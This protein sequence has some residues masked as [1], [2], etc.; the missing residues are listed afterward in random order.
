MSTRALA[1]AP[2]GAVTVSGPSASDARSTATSAQPAARSAADVGGPATST[3]STTSSGQTLAM[4]SAMPG[5]RTTR[6]VP[7]PSTWTPAPIGGRFGPR[8]TMSSLLYSTRTARPWRSA[9][10]LA[11]SADL[12]RHLAPEG[13]AVGQRRHRNTARLAPRCVGLEV[14]GFDPRRLQR[15]VPV[16]WWRVDRPRQRRCGAPS[17]HLGGHPP[18]LAERLA[19]VPLARR[20]REQR[21]VHPRAP[22]RRR[23]RPCRVPHGRRPT[24]RSRPPTA[25]ARSTCPVGCRGNRARSEGQHGVDDG[26]PSGAPAQVGGEGTVHGVDRRA[27]L[28]RRDAH[29]D[30]RRAEPALRRA[31]R[32]ERLGPCHRVGEPIDRRDVPPG[33]AP[34]GCHARNAWLAVDEHGAAPALSLRAAPILGRARAEAVAQNLE[35]GDVSVRDLDGTTVE[36]ERD[37]EK[38]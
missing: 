35:E 29:D 2:F 13:T 18:R 34:D 30:P 5:V 37:Q 28:H 14:A 24:G 1:M 10:R 4:A 8:R 31:A 11:T 22:C 25:P 27:V 36:A 32:H 3:S 15:P 20:R 19:D 16:T 21:P 26:P 12:A 6:T 33:D 17:L 38:L 7:A 9:R 23:T